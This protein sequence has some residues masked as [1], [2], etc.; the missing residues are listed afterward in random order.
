MGKNTIYCRIRN[1]LKKALKKEISAAQFR[2]HGEMPS[3]HD[4]HFS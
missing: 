2:Q 1:V 3:I 4:G